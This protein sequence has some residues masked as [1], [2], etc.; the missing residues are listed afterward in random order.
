MD[1]I[2]VILRIVLVVLVVAIPCACRFLRLER[3]HLHLPFVSLELASRESKNEGPEEFDL[4]FDDEDRQV[5]VAEH[6]AELPLPLA[7][8]A[9][10]PPPLAPPLRRRTVVE[11]RRD[12]DRAVVSAAVSAAA[13]SSSGGDLGPDIMPVR[14]VQTQSEFTYTS[15]RNVCHPRF[16]PVAAGY[17]RVL[18]HEHSYATRR[19]VQ[20]ADKTAQSMTAHPGSRFVTM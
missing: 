5:L 17:A 12:R 16:Y 6:E 18:I 9:E 11:Q 1:L 19:R 10:L 20:M 3:I 13:S 4:G 14:T 2:K 8:E 7:P 15:L